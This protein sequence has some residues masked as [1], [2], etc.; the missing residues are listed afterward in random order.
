MCIL[1]CLI[2]AEMSLFVKVLFCGWLF[3]V[4]ADISEP[5]MP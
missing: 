2:V 5:S 4:V 1:Y 3:F